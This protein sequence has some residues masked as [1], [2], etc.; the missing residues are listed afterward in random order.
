MSKTIVVLNIDFF[1]LCNI[2]VFLDEILV[3]QNLFGLSRYLSNVFIIY[4][5]G[6]YMR[7]N[8]KSCELL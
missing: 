4:K 2:V 8:Y 1:C 3:I 6:C 5:F 7:K